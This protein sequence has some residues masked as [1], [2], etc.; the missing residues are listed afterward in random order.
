MKEGP[1]DENPG[2]VVRK[3]LQQ[4]LELKDFIKPAIDPNEVG[5]AEKTL[6]AWAARPFDVVQDF[7]NFFVVYY[8]IVKLMRVY[9]D[10]ENF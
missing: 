5:Q 4:L 9:P 10:C 6:A 8:A 2:S 1:Y 3:S 7:Y